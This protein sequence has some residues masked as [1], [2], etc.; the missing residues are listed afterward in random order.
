MSKIVTMQEKL[1]A[2]ENLKK[3]CDN[4]NGRKP[5][6]S[7][8][9]SCDYTE[10]TSFYKWHFGSVYNA[11]SLIYPDKY[12][13]KEKYTKEFLIHEFKRVEEK[14]GYVPTYNNMKEH[15][16]IHPRIYQEK[17][18]SWNSFLKEMNVT[19]K[20]IMKRPGY[21]KRRNSKK[22]YIAKDN[23]K[24]Y[25]KGELE[26]DNFFF[27][28][29]IPHE[30]EVPYPPHPELNN[31]GRKLADWKI[32]DI[33]VEYLGMLNHHSKRIKKDYMDREFDKS[34]ILLELGKNFMFIYPDSLKNNK[35]SIMNFLRGD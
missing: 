3:L 34:R 30:K 28:M 21:K 26:L 20:D 23:H 10:S 5:T 33:Y 4:L 19:T 25:S 16:V 12:K 27:D 1:K 9:D 24:C 18:G 29:G 2:L 6:R 11:L 14:L 15:S 32:K 8:I 17:F 22:S 13:R 7:D 35:R 31:N